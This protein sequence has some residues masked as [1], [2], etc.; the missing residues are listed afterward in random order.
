MNESAIE[1]RRLEKSFPKFKLGPFDLSVP[2]GAREISETP[3]SLE[4]LFVTLAA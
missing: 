1:I 4:D 2:Q 3:V